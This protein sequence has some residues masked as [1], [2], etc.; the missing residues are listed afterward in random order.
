MIEFEYKGG[1]GPTWDEVYFSNYLIG[2]FCDV[3]AN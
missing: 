2:L 1:G 3:H